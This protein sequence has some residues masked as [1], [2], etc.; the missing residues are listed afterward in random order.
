MS[1]DV[2]NEGPTEMSSSEGAITIDQT[3]PTEPT[4]P[5]APSVPDKFRNPDGSV[6]TD[7]L[8]KSYTELEK[9]KSSPTPEV[10]PEV[11]PKEGLEITP[12][13]KT[14]DVQKAVGEE[15]FK[16]IAEYYGEHQE[17]SEELYTKLDE[18]GYSKSFTDAWIE[19]QKSL[20]SK[21]ESS[22]KA[23]AGGE[24]QYAEMITWAR[25][26]LTEAERLMYDEAVESKDPVRAKMA[27]GFLKSRY[28][29]A[30]G[31]PPRLV[32]GSAPNAT[33]G[34]QSEEE[35]AQAIN[36]PRWQKDV[37]FTRAIM[38]RLKV[39]TY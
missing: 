16:E 28:I 1:A 3:V 26:G 15:L 21:Y 37:A 2:N 7:A 5:E 17:I 38:D 22:V 6:N 13:V 8:L 23:E 39:S 14:E 32:E 29:S 27:V 36:D 20:R 34:F 12:P 18:K 25:E 33:E 35:F 9:M 31:K 30:E 24:E 4:S 19:G 11:P 10:T